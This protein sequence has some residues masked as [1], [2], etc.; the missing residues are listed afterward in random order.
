[1][2]KWKTSMPRTAPANGKVHIVVAIKGAGRCEL[3]GELPA[4]QARASMMLAQVSYE[5]FLALQAAMDAVAKPAGG[6][7]QCL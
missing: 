4:D 2:S 3:S 5:R 1:M 7:T 6:V